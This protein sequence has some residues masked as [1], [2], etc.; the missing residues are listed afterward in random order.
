[1]TPDKPVE[2]LPPA[3]PFNPTLGRS[4]RIVSG[5]SGNPSGDSQRSWEAKGA[6]GKGFQRV[7][8]VGPPHR[9]ACPSLMLS[10]ILFFITAGSQVPVADDDHGVMK[11]SKKIGKHLSFLC[12]ILEKAA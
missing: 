7:A 6:T 5:M 9:A 11:A 10:H 1:M 3:S 2:P 4:S 8:C 12:F